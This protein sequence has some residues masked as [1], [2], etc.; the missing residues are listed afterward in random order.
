MGTKQ[1]TE[2]KPFKT[3][4]T[5]EKVIQRL[6]DL[7]VTRLGTYMVLGLF[8][9]WSLFPLYWMV[10]GSLKTRQTILA[11]PP[12]W[13]P[14]SYHFANYVE[15]FA[16][17]PDILMFIRNSVIV[18][19]SSAAVSV[20]IGVAAAYALV[21]FDYPYK[22]NDIFPIYLLAT[23]FLPPVVA[24]I[25]LYLIFR[26]LN[27]INTLYALILIYSTLNLVFVVWMMKGFFEEFPDSIIEAALLDGH[28]H[29]GA[30]FKVVLPAVKPGILASTIFAIMT[31]W[32][33]LLLAIILANDANAMTIPV[34]MAGFIT[35][36]YIEWVYIS[37]LGTIA[38]IPIV[39]FA[40]SARDELIRGFS[41]GAVDK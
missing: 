22:L 25:P 39:V 24:A 31:S 26:Q 37:V 16:A 23:R 4:S 2:A 3:P 12:H 13:I 20:S 27:L 29:I 33:E 38:I 35:R 30:F 28:T 32:N 19:I 6:N 34:G 36:F 1:R 14:H 9:F 8:F 17:R 15:M 18:T 11:S 5:G 21:K 10:T 7:G 41:M 40:F